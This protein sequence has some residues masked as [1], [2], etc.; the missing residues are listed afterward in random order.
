MDRKCDYDNI[1]MGAEGKVNESIKKAKNIPVG[2]GVVDSKPSSENS[3]VSNYDANKGWFILFF[4]WISGNECSGV[5]V[6]SVIN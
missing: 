5:G 6:K 2:L 3:H 4:D 1:L